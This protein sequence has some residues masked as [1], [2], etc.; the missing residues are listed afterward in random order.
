MLDILR[1]QGGTEQPRL[2]RPLALSLAQQLGRQRH[3]QPRG[4]QQQREQLQ[5]E[6]NAHDALQQP[7]EQPQQ[8]QQMR[9]YPRLGAEQEFLA[10]CARRPAGLQ[11][12][13]V[14]AAA[15]L[16]LPRPRYPR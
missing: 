14:L 7:D 13:A 2:P 15:A 5:R 6:R 8:E 11:P 1:R 9:G 12:T 4:G 3:Q 16:D 10:W